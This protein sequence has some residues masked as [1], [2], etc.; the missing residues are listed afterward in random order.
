M[1][2]HICD[3]KALKNVYCLEQKHV[4]AHADNNRC[5]C[6]VC[7]KPASSMLIG[8][9]MRSDLRP[10]FQAPREII[11]EF[12]QKMET[13]TRF[14]SFHRSHYDQFRENR[15]IFWLSIIYIYFYKI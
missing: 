2:Y 13:I 14:Q 3:R 10:F 5:E 7:M 6:N 11:A 12:A 4:N 9:S 8:S 1:G 15:V